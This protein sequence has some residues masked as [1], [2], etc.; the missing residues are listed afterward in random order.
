MQNEISDSLIEIHY[1]LK[2]GEPALKLNSG[3]IS[4]IRIYAIVKTLT[5]S[6][7]SNTKTICD[8]A[9]ISNLKR[10]FFIRNKV[11]KIEKE[12]LMS[13]ISSLLKIESL[14]KKGNNP[15]NIFTENL[16]SLN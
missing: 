2:K 1:L 15:I 14:L 12:Y 6:G 7:E 4:Q 8:I 16:I 10:I 3:L 9:G 5:N 13:L 11:I